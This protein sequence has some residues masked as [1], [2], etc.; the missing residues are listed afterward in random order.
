MID[1]KFIQELTGILRRWSASSSKLNG[2]E[3]P[4]G[5]SNTRTLADQ[6]R[7]HQTFPS[8]WRWLRCIVVYSIECFELL[9]EHFV[10]TGRS[11]GLEVQ[12]GFTASRMPVI[13]VLDSKKSQL[14]EWCRTNLLHEVIPVFTGESVEVWSLNSTMLDHEQLCSTCKDKTQIDQL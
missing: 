6:K 12:R 3:R 7:K 4:C 9:I 13:Y 1:L 14:R 10:S 8:F 2:W 11:R 5:C